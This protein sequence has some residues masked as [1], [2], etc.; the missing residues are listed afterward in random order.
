[1]PFRI[2]VVVFAR[3]V[4]LI[5]SESISTVSLALCVN[6]V[7]IRRRRRLGLRVISKRRQSEVPDVLRDSGGD[8]KLDLQL[9]A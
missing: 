8:T 2:V 6:I 3:L 9:P 7:I 1:M 5:T 4:F